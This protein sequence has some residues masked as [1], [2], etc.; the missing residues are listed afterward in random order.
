MQPTN[1]EHVPQLI[2]SGYLNLKS[3]SQNFQQGVSGLYN[4]PEKEEGT[5]S[6]PA[7]NPFQPTIQETQVPINLGLLDKV[8]NKGILRLKS[9]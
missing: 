1:L 8:S 7:L 6:D 3:D 2:G 9:K 5:E 4:I